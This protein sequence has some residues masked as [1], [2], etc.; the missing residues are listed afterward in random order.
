MGCWHRFWPSLHSHVAIL[1][2]NL[3]FIQFIHLYQPHNSRFWAR[4][5]D[6]NLMKVQNVLKTSWLLRVATV[7]C[8]CPW[9]VKACKQ[10]LSLSGLREFIFLLLLYS[11][12]DLRWSWQRN[13]RAIKTIAKAQL[14]HPTT[15]LYCSIDS[16][17]RDCTCMVAS[18]LTS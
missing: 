15:T 4:Q 12:S 2:I 14:K 6:W 11:T 18:T 5:G 9:E 1:Q 10:I 3:Y 16:M 17:L 7:H 13:Q 8:T